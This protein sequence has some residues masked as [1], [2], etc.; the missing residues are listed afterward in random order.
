V[1]A[2]CDVV[3]WPGAVA[4]SVR[5]AVAERCDIRAEDV[6][7]TGSHTHA[8]V[9][10][11]DATIANW[12]HD[13]LCEAARDLVEQKVVE[14]AVGAVA[15]LQS[16]QLQVV[17][18]ACGVARS[19]RQ[20]VDGR[21]LVGVDEPAA[22]AFLDV[23]ALTRPDG[24]PLASVVVYGMHPTV[25]AWGSLVFS[26][27]YVGRLREVVERGLG[28]PCLFLQGCGADRAPAHSFSNSTADADTVGAAVG[29]SAAAAM[30]STRE[31]V[32]KARPARII[33]SGAPL[34]DNTLSA[35]IRSEA[36]VVHSRSEITM[37]LRHRD[38]A[39]TRE[40][41]AVARAAVA[42][43]ESSAS[44][45]LARAVIELDIAQR[46]PDGESSNVLVDL[47]EIGNL[48]LVFWPGELSGEYERLCQ[49]ETNRHVV[50]VTNSNDYVN[51]LPAPRQFAEGGYEVDASPFTAEGGLAFVRGVRRLVGEGV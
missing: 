30:L 17:R 22:D 51:Y 4:T 42:R 33:E 5:E 15:N 27:D 7:L 16:A 45:E 10:M 29:Y 18:Q 3:L 47:V 41:V 35:P 24:T 49:E 26:P 34:V 38:L 21:L 2:A 48:V 8:S 50:L 1:I 14:A 37:P 43:G 39:A 6:Q 36:T 19:R 40:R 13:G 23:I 12:E 31:V 9:M 44:V 46:F 28:G 11:D 25:L 32:L 20:M